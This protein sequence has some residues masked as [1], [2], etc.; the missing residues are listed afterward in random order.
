MAEPFQFDKAVLQVVADDKQ[1]I[2]TLK[3]DEAAVNASVNK[4]QGDLNKLTVSTASMGAAVGV[5]G[6]AVGALGAAAA[7][8][9]NVALAGAAQVATFAVA[10]GT[11]SVAAAIAKTELVALTVATKAYVVANVA[12]TIALAALAAAI[13]AVRVIKGRAAQKELDELKELEEASKKSITRFE[14]ELKHRASIAAITDKIAVAEGRLSKETARLNELRRADRGAVPGQ[15]EERVAAETR[16]ASVLATKAAEAA[17][18]V[19]ARVDAEQAVVRQKQ[20]ALNLATQQAAAEQRITDE[21][22][23]RHEARFVTPFEAR[24]V[25]TAAEAQRLVMSTL[26]LVEANQR[27]AAL[28][29]AAFNRL[30]AQAARFGLDQD[31]LAKLRQT[32][33]I[34]AEKPTTRF[35]AGALAITGFAATGTKG[36][37]G[38]QGAERQREQREEKRTAN[39]DAIAANT[40]RLAKA[41]DRWQ[42]LGAG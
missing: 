17:A 29:T 16:L 27:A 9:G 25:T 35:G 18:A 41:F 1:M 23:R 24:G 39:S 2:A 42:P 7:A 26:G 31:Q 10:I 34:E 30:A 28:T 37:A 40:D 14:K 12:A 6:A 20:E 11:M 33:G 32:L 8:S 38:L 3:K 19:K 15:L 5:M 22:A 21:I 4:M 36:I 13:I